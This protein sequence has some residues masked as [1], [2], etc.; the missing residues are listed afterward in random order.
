MTGEWLSV[1]CWSRR[2]LYFLKNLLRKES[3]AVNANRNARR[4]SRTFAA[5]PAKSWNAVWKSSSLAELRNS[6]ANRSSPSAGM[7]ADKVGR[8]DID[9]VMPYNG[10][11]LG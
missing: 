4:L 5:E 2:C 10:F 1:L 6:E 7:G 8:A 9:A 11:P 3:S